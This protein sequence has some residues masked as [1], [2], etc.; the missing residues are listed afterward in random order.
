[1]GVNE[2]FSNQTVTKIQQL[3]PL[4]P[5]R[6]NLGPAPLI[7]AGRPTGRAGRRPLKS[8]ARTPGRRL[9]SAPPASHP[10]RGAVR[11]GADGPPGAPGRY[12]TALPGAGRFFS[13][14]WDAAP[15]WPSGPHN[16][17]QVALNVLCKKKKKTLTPIGPLLMHVL[18]YA[19]CYLAYL[20]LY[21]IS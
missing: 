11:A 4:R 16:N 6:A 18:S 21:S 3:P 12:P 5:I 17:A 10:F 15:A 8:T 14:R 7:G 13:P 1:M 19:P 2:T 9:G 20:S